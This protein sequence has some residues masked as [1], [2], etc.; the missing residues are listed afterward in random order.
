MRSSTFP[1]CTQTDSG[2]R[3]VRTCTSVLSSFPANAPFTE[4]K[5]GRLCTLLDHPRT[6][7]RNWLCPDLG[8]PSEETLLQDLLPCHLYCLCWVDVLRAD[9]A[10]S[11]GHVASP[12]AVRSVQQVYSLV[13]TLISRV[14]HVPVRLCDCL[15]PNV[16]R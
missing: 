15:R 12:D 13:P 4:V 14:R 5:G 16:C 11:T 7:E 8:L 6:Q 9:E 1:R 2:W 10:A 3:S